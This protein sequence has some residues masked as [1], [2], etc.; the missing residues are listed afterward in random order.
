MSHIRRLDFLGIPS[1][2]A[3]RARSFYVDTLGLRPD[4][5]AAYECWAGDTCFGIWQPEQ[6]GMPF[7]AQQGNPLPLGVDDVHAAR[8][9]LEAEGVTFLGDT[10][11]TG[12]CHMAFFADPDG[13]ALMLHHRYAP[14]P[15]AA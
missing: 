1:R 15:D 12:V 8:A 4:E 7:V 13:N 6:V 5:H 2:D 14:Y 11:D 3:D 9:D 10:M